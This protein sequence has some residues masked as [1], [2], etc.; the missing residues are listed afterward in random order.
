[1]F[2]FYE[3]HKG[4]W[5]SLLMCDDV[6][7]PHQISPAVRFEVAFVEASIAWYRGEPL[8]SEDWHVRC[9][10]WQVFLDGAIP[11]NDWLINVGYS[12][13]SLYNLI[14][15]YCMIKHDKTVA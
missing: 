3:S 5:N 9:Y 11:Q 15:Q 2:F 6:C 14:I 1:M 7:F 4:Q 13:Y 8:M 10:R 12:Y